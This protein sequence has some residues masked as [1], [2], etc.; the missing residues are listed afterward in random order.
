MTTVE[1]EIRIGGNK[2]G[3]VFIVTEERI[4]GESSMVTG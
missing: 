1:T 4:Y 3:G 2:I